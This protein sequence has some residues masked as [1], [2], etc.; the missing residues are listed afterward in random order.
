MTGKRGW[1]DLVEE[2]LLVWNGEGNL[3]ST[4]NGQALARLPSERNNF[5]I[6]F[7]LEKGFPNDLMNRYHPRM[8]IKTKGILFYDDDGPFYSRNAIVGGF[9]LW[10]RNANA[11]MGAMARR[12]DLTN[13]VEFTDDRQFIRQCPEDMA[14]YNYHEFANYHARMVLPSGSFLHSNYLCFLWHPVFET[15]R[16]FVRAHP[17][18]P[19]DVTV[20]TII[21][22]IAGRAPK[23]YPRRINTANEARR[24]QQESDMNE[25][26]SYPR[27]RLLWDDVSKDEW[28][29]MRSSAVNSL[30]SYFGSINS[31]S[32][33][34][35]HDTPYSRKTKDG[36][37]CEPYMARVGMLPWL[38]ADHKPKDT[39]P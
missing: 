20:S 32:L 19:D 29:K 31:G 9:E 11:Q 7:P 12:I 23:V 26:H 5:R 1:G 3:T 2:V 4:D 30:T 36:Y 13:E 18:H 17:V 16:Q 22:Q 25:T 39:C 33:G 6:F 21:S 37:V 35:C 15:I 14:T 34:W 24:L 8:E 27:R 10:K 38:T 28:A